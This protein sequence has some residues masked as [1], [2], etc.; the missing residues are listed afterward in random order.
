M[1]SHRKFGIVLAIVLI[2]FMV[3]SVL[4]LTLVFLS[5]NQ[6]QT[7]KKTEYNTRA[8]YLAYSGI[9][10]A[11]K[12]IESN[13]YSNPIILNG[14][15]RDDFLSDDFEVLD[16]T[17]SSTSLDSLRNDISNL[18]NDQNSN[19]IVGVY[20]DQ[21]KYQYFS[22]GIISDISKLITLEKDVSITSGGTSSTFD[23]AVFSTGEGYSFSINPAWAK[24][25]GDAGTNS[26]EYEVDTFGEKIT[27]SFTP[28]Q[29]ITIEVPDFPDLDDKGDL[30]V[31]N[32]KS[33]T[34][35]ES[36]EYNDVNVANMGDITFQTDGSIIEMVVN[37]NFS[38][39]CL[40]ETGTGTVVIYTNSG[41]KISG[42]SEIDGDIVIYS[43]GDIDLQNAP[44]NAQMFSIIAPNNDVKSTGGSDVYGSIIADTI[45]IGGNSHIYYKPINNDIIIVNT[46]ESSETVVETWSR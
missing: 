11:S 4:S 39:G 38:L 32:K 42:Q 18:N 1:N 28:G 23:Y 10:I 9:E 8:H 6:L 41:F 36:C 25:Y 13:T 22:R 45:T 16:W 19:I 33:F 26:D 2:V 30:E 14:T 17:P 31:K 29:N 3:F 7:M 24:I 34:I 12:Y 43:K 15:L 46:G 5:A 40:Y 44:K 21:N 20:K 37:G 35:S 27:G